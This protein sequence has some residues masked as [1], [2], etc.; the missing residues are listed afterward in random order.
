MGTS[1]FRRAAPLFAVVLC[2]PISAQVTQRVNVKTGGGQGNGGTVAYSM[3]ISADGRYVAF[4]DN[5]TDLV[6][7]DTN[8][9]D[10]I[11]VRDRIAGTTERVSVATGGAQADGGSQ[12]PSISA[13]GRFVAF[14]SAASNLVPG[15]TNGKR[16]IFV[17]DRQTG[18][19]VRVNVD[20]SGLQANQDSD[21][22]S[23]SADGRYVAFES[24][25]DNLVAGDSDVASDV[26]VHDVLTGI[27][28]RVSVSSGGVQGND[29]SY[30]PSISADGRFVAFKSYASNLVA[31]DTNHFVDVFVRDRLAGTTQRVSVPSSGA[32]ASGDSGYN[33]LA[34]AG[35]GRTVAFASHAGNLVPDDTN[36]F[37]DAFVHDRDSTGFTSLCDP[38]LDGVIGCPCANPPSAT[39]RGCDNSAGTG[40]ADLSASG[41]A[42]LSMD[43]LVLTAS[44]EKPTATSIGLQGSP[45]AASGFVHG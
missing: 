29:R 24:L 19:T 18:T 25:A 41:I 39:G 26:F 6:P 1:K 22:P 44:H 20:S 34:I 4:V 40:G 32:Q 5:S 9:F 37:T 43:S 42:Y 16:D 17:P 10:D 3:S 12:L 31:G 35:D 14:E 8:G 45:P 13:D 21:A 2:A 38:G 7:G 33:G 30:L 15:D 36:F 23:I 27:T 11:F 28:E